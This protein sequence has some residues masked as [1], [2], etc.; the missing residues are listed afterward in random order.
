M[1][2]KNM[3]IEFIG[4]FKKLKS[5][6]YRYQKLF[7]HNYI[8]YH[9]NE[10]W[11]WKKGNEVE[12]TDFNTRS[13]KLFEYLVLN[14]FII[15]NKFNIVVFNN[16]TFKMEEYDKTKHEDVHQFEKLTEEEM[17]QFYKTYKKTLLDQNIIDELKYLYE[18]KLIKLSEKK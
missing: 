2:N 18:N 9:K 17:N 5:M 15:N 7:A 14:N 3:K 13:S 10:L 8:C 16:S 6:G 4:D 1:R 11:I 12:I